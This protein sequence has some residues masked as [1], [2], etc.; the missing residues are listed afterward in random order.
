MH[1]TILTINSLIT[2][3][4]AVG[5]KLAVSITLWSPVVPVLLISTSYDLVPN[6]NPFSLIPLCLYSDGLYLFCNFSPRSWHYRYYRCSPCLWSYRCQGQLLDDSYLLQLL[7]CQGVI[8][9]R[10]KGC[11][12]IPIYCK[13]DCV[14][15]LWLTVPKRLNKPCFMYY[16]T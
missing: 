2:I 12:C 9:Y 3:D 8:L 16:I 13:W 14:K 7:P 10:P 1:C 6:Y 15:V 11:M 4:H 5:Y